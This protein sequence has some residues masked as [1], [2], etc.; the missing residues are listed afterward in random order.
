MK[1][2][3]REARTNRLF[4]ITQNDLAKA[5]GIHP[6]QMSQIERGVY[7]PSLTLALKISKVLKVP[8]D[9]LFKLEPEDWKK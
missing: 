7:K 4:K 8:L 5:V 3:I 2:Y 6:S 9:D 1:N